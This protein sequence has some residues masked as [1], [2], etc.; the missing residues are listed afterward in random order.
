[1]TKKLRILLLIVFIFN[2]GQNAFAQSKILEG[3]WKASLNEKETLTIK[4]SGTRTCDVEINNHKAATP[5]VSYS[6]EDVVSGSTDSKN[7]P[8]TFKLAFLTQA[9]VSGEKC[10][11]NTMEFSEPKEKIYVTKATL[12]KSG[13]QLKIK[14][15]FNMPVCD[16][17]DNYP[18]VAEITLNKQ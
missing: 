17:Q 3:T 12:S 2:I 18:G 8:L 14:V 1:M 11:V 6:I 5:V 9:S 4:F 7:S 15:D 10:N 13:K 16:F